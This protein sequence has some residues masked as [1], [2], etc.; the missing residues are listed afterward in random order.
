MLGG[1]G[2]EQGELRTSPINRN[3]NLARKDN[4]MIL[5]TAIVKIKLNRYRIHCYL[6]YNIS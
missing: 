3:H 6:P 4:H 5:N 1:G 2:V